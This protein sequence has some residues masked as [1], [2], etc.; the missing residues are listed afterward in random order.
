MVTTLQCA[1]NRIEGYSFF[2]Y[3]IYLF[4]YLLCPK[5]K[6]AFRSLFALYCFLFGA[7]FVLKLCLCVCGLN[8][9]KKKK[10]KKK[11]HTQE[12]LLMPIAIQLDSYLH[13]FS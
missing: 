6:N 8:I 9:P 12:A 2:I 11:T 1:E 5:L 4:I 7:V 10:K 13:A 3:F